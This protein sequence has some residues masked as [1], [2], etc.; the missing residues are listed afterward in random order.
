MDEFLKTFEIGRSLRMKGCPYD[1][2]VAKATF[3]IIKTEFVNQ[4]NFQSL[5]HL[6]LELYDYSCPLSKSSP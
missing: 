5:I 1:N 3:K 6:E 4:M 2:A